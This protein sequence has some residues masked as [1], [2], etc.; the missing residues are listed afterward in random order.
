MV[1]ALRGKDY[2]EYD[3]PNDVGM[4]S[5]CMGNESMASRFY[6]ALNDDGPGKFLRQSLSTQSPFASTTT[7]VS[8]GG[9]G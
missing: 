7:T 5:T 1:H 3:N 6:H 9:G 8:N 2:V 4:L